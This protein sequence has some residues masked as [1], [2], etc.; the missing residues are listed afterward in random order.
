M[1][2]NQMAVRYT[3][4]NATSLRDVV[5][6]LDAAMTTLFEVDGLCKWI[7]KYDE[8]NADSITAILTVET[9]SLRHVLTFGGLEES[10]FLNEIFRR[11]RAIRVRYDE[12]WS[13]QYRLEVLC[14]NGE[15]IPFPAAS[16]GVDTRDRAK[17]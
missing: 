11:C 3:V 17:R 9:E 10:R 7:E 8:R 2:V 1:V 5:L 14:H 4:V 6:L 16:F 12:E 15:F 13:P